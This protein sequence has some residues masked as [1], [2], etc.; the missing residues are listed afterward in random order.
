MC[1]ICRSNPCH[2]RCPNAEEKTTRYVCFCC[3][4]SILIGEEF[5]MSEAGNTV[6]AD[7]FGGMDR[8]DVFRFFGEEERVRTVESIYEDDE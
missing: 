1:D 3:G 4:E 7:C 8:E 2:P 5:L 6:H